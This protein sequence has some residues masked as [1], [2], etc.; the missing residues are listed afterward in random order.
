MMHSTQS[1]AK[2][3]RI[4]ALGLLLARWYSRPWRWQRSPPTVCE[5]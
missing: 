3:G 4:L 2:V 1:R 5:R